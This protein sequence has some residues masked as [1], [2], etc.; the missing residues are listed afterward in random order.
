MFVVEQVYCSD[1]F[2]FLNF[3]FKNAVNILTS[4]KLQKILFN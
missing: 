1:V 4:C 2:C 3:A